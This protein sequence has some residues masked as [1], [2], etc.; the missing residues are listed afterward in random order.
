MCFCPRVNNNALLVLSLFVGYE[1]SLNNLLMMS[2]HVNGTR[3]SFLLSVLPG[4]FRH[5]SFHLD[6]IAVAVVVIVVSVAAAVL[7]WKL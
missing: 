2:A 5:R 6:F 4:S 3:S 7:I 1:D